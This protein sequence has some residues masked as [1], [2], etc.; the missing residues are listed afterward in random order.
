MVNEKRVGGVPSTKYQV[1]IPS[2]GTENQLPYDKPT[3][4]KQ[5]KLQLLQ[6]FQNSNWISVIETINDLTLYYIS[7]SLTLWLTGSVN[8]IPDK[9]KFTVV[10]WKTN[11]EK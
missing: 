6:Q 9:R 10:I 2:E 3:A 7:F 5:Q 4:N 11:N 8:N 1:G